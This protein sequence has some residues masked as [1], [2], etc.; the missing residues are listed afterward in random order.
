MESVIVILNRHTTINKDCGRLPGCLC[1]QVDVNAFDGLLSL[2]ELQ[3]GH[4]SIKSLPEGS[5]SPLQSL[6]RL[7]L[8]SNKLESLKDGTFK[9]LGNLTALYLHSNN[10]RT[11]HAD[12]LRDTPK[13]IKLCEEI[14]NFNPSKV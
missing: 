5:F 9:G 7:I 4:N 6:E 12:L 11:L 1:L 8:Y 2:K 13:L 10:L 3:L 14:L